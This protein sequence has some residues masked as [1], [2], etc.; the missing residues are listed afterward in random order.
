VAGHG[1]AEGPE[2]GLG[3]LVRSMTGNRTHR[4]TVRAVRMRGAAADDRAR[5]GYGEGLRL[6]GPRGGR[7]PGTC[8]GAMARG[9]TVAI[10]RAA[11]RR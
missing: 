10:R 7:A 2:E 1:P 9:R 11:P 4:A 5:R 3:A 8:Q 6:L